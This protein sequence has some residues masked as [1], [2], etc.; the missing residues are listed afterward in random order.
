MANDNSS[1]Y[2]K[3]LPFGISNSDLSNIIDRSGNSSDRMSD[4]TNNIFRDTPIGSITDAIG[5]SFFGINHRQQPGAIPI[6]KDLYGLTFFTRP[7]LNLTSD[8]LTAI[9]LLNP[10]LTNNDKSI[11]RIIRSTL[12]PNLINL[13]GSDRVTCP[14]V[15]PQQAFIP[16]LTNNLLSISGWPDVVAPTMTSTEGVYK[17]QFSMIDGITTNYSTYDITASFRNIPGD[18]ITLLFLV[19]I[20]YASNVFQGT[21]TPYPDKII[22]TEI[23][24]NTRIYRLVL[25]STKTYVNKIAATGAAFPLSSPIGAAFNMEAGAQITDANHQISI[26]MRCM[27]AIYQDDILIEEFNATSI[28]FN[29]GLD[30]NTYGSDKSARDYYYTKIPIKALGLFNNKGYPIINP[31]T[32]ELEWYIENDVFN[33]LYDPVSNSMNKAS[34]FG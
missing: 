28:K 16:L 5:N 29:P 4:E 34:I 2:G 22:N 32:Y 20:H 33:T 3:N 13:L 17:E 21:M 9:R 27:G 24:Y 31:D 23:D 15:D 25:D 7:E 14:L 6:N 30:Y 8:N 1:G 11:Q 12:D 10:L 18:P 26:P 19:W